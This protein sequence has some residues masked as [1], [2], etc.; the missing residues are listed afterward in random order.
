MSFYAKFASYYEEIFPFS[1]D[2]VK[3]LRHFN[4][5]P[6]VCLDIGCGTGHYAG[7]FVANGYKATGIDLDNA[8]IAYAQKHYPGVTFRCMDMRKINEIAAQFN[9]VYCIG[10]SAA[11][12]PRDD[13]HR[14]VNDSRSVFVPGGT[15]VLQLMNWDYVL[16]QDIVRFPT[17]TTENELRFDRTY[18]HI[19]GECVHFETSLSRGTGTI[20]EDSVPLYPITSEDLILMHTNLGFKLDSHFGNYSFEPFNPGLFSANIL[21]FTAPN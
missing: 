7:D 15:W 10:N 17:I 2:V 3:F 21:V 12:L 16:T 9:F 13:F 6:N 5:T 8:M 18:T 14:F 11:H 4:R 1:P 19:S 20:F